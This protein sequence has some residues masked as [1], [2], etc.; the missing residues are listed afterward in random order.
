MAND[1]T[2]GWLQDL[3]VLRRLPQEYARAID[4]RDLDAV[5]ALFDAHAVIDGARGSLGIDEWLGGMRD[6]EPAFTTSMHVLGAPLIDVEPG[7]DI[8]HMDTYAVVYQLGRRDDPDVDLVLGIRYHD[9]L[10]RRD[11]HW[12]IRHRRAEA[13]WTRTR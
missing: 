5:A 3:E 12:L 13:L 8:A 4:T 1:Q 11:G 2:T 9:D 6:A 7:S 10:V